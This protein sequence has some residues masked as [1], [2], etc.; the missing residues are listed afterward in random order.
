MKIGDQVYVT[1]AN[2]NT[3]LRVVVA[4]ENG[5]AY[6]SKDEEIRRARAEER[7]PTCIGFPLSSI[8]AP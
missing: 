2:D 3:L 5:Y 7:E 6:V 4:I 8:V 1:D